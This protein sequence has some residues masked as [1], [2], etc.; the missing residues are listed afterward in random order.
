MKRVIVAM[1]TTSVLVS[2]LIIG[3]PAQAACGDRLPGP[4]VNT[5]WL[6]SHADLPGLVLID[7]RTA[8]E[9]QAGHIAN[10][11]NIPLEVPLS[12]W[13]TMRDDL[14][15]ELPDPAELFATLGGFGISRTSQIV[16]ITSTG[17]PPYPE[18]NATRVAVTLR[19][20]GAHNVAILDGG[21]PKWAAEGRPVTT[22]VPQPRPVAYNGTV[23]T[24]RF[25]DIAYVHDHI[26][27]SLIVDARDAAVYSGEVTEPWAEKP[28][29]IPSARSLPST[30]IWEADGGYRSVPE[31]RQLARDVVGAN[32]SAEIIVYC[33]VGGYASAWTHVLSEILG[34][35]NVKMYDGSAQEWVRYYDME[36][37]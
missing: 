33:G 7:I 26:G 22:A 6:E 34:Y 18:A 1:A 15:L 3:D 14:L 25:V 9:Y 11:V 37:E 2:S 19:Y 4:L 8:A 16:I 32:K 5:D 28:G 30:L 12:A 27:E 23:N 29:H 24:R 13:I 17:Q 35:T 36:I 10:A 20:A 31:L 21:H